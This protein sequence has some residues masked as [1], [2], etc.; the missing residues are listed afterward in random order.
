MNEAKLGR[1]TM[2]L[3]IALAVFSAIG[4]TAGVIISLGFDE[5]ALISLSGVPKKLELAASGSWLGVFLGT[6]PGA[7]LML[8][9]A[10]FCGFCAVSQPIELLLAA[11]RGLGLGVCVRGIYLSDSILKSMAAFLPFAILS[12]GVLILGIREAFR[13]SMRYFS[14]ST[15]NE[16]RLGILNEIRDYTARFLIYALMLAALSMADAFLAGVISGM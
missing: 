14:L 7:L 1:R 3:D 12:T 13:L 5:A 9:A 2:S 15:T 16:N 4:V 8:A 11:F 6:F 10:F